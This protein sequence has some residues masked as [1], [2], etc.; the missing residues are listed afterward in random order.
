MVRWYGSLRLYYVV[1]QIHLVNYMLLFLLSLRVPF[2]DISYAIFFYFRK[3]EIYLCVADHVFVNLKML[4]FVHLVF[5]CW[6]WLSNIFDATE[7]YK[8]AS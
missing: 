8:C 6:N 3:H 7:C 1:N 5:T 4:L 2:L